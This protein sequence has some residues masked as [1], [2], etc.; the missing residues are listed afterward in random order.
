VLH[1]C[2]TPACVNPNHLFLGTMKDNTQDAI[3]K[4]RFI[5]PQYKKLTAVDIIKIRNDNR[6]HELIAIDFGVTSSNICYIKANK[7]WRHICE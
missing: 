4:N 2:D 1:V 5:I 6:T 7:T 3:K